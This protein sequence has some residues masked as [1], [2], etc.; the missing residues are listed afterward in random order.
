MVLP[1]DMTHM[2][3]PPDMTHMVLMTDNGATTR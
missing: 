2:V 3:L 1:P